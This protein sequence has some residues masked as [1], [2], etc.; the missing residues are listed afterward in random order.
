M[1]IKGGERKCQSNALATSHY[2]RE[3]V[4]GSIRSRGRPRVH[5]ARQ[6]THE[7]ED[8]RPHHVAQLHVALG[9]LRT[10]RRLGAPRAGE[11]GM[12]LVAPKVAPTTSRLLPAK[13]QAACSHLPENN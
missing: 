7:H 13:Q 5:P 11:V 1:P 8:P 12:A 4:G 3:Q 9:S 2:G 6:W 10:R